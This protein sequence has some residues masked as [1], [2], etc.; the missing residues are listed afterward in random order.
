MP[1]STF[2]HDYIVFI[3]RGQPFTVAHKAIEDY[4]LTKGKKTITIFGSD[5]RPETQKNP[6]PADVRMDLLDLVYE[7]SPDHERMIISSTGDFAKNE[8]FIASVVGLVNDLI[9][10]D[11]G[12][13][14]TATI[15]I[16]G[17]SA[18]GDPSAFYLEMFDMW[19]YVPSPEFP[20]IEGFG[21]VRAT[22]V[23]KIIFGGDLDELVNVVP[24][25]VL[26]YLKIFRGTETYK[27]L[28]SEVKAVNTFKEKLPSYPINCVTTD[29]MLVC[30]DY[31]LLITRSKVGKGLK[32]LPGGFLEHNL[33]IEQNLYKELGE[34]SMIEVPVSELKKAFLGYHVEDDVNRSERC[35]ILTH[36]GVFNLALIGYSNE[37]LPKVTGGDDAASA[38]W[39]LKDELQTDEF[40]EDHHFLIQRCESKFRFC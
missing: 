24:E 6:F 13:P 17:Y 4:A 11:G 10:K 33:R 7:N 5:N 29:A 16:T 22:N 40:F 38:D 9:A 18:E 30:G 23:R 1:S 36:V 27:R 2:S 12:D 39:Y 20:L 32:A 37:N 19:D 25:P 21:E 31:I 8:D 3:L 28:L 15:G 14:K 34:E 26:W 35:R